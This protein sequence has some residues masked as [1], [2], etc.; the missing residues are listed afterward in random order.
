MGSKYFNK[1]IEGNQKGQG[2]HF[3]LSG[4]SSRTQLWKELRSMSPVKVSHLY[5]AV[6]I[7]DKPVSLYLGLLERSGYVWRSPGKN[8]ACYLIK[9]TGPLAPTVCRNNNDRY[10]LS[11]DNTGE[12]VEVPDTIDKWPAEP[13]EPHS[14]THKIWLS[15]RILKV[16]TVGELVAI[17]GTDEGTVADRIAELCEYRY[18]R[19][20]YQAQY[21]GKINFILPPYRDT[22]P[23]AP[24]VNHKMHLLYDY[25]T[26]EVI[27]GE[28]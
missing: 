25:N 23:R 14:Q 11:D 5:E 24:V 26:R 15:M 7:T 1:Q 2:S 9:N 20:E 27:K 21:D 22:G 19:S 18:L 17:T 12:I 28:K 6:N 10:Q 3:R 8:R 16:F 13:D 4:Q